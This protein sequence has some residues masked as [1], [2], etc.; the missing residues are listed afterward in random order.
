MPVETLGQERFDTISSA[1]RELVT[2]AAEVGIRKGTA[3]LAEIDLDGLEDE[4]SRFLDDNSGA[5]VGASYDYLESLVRKSMFRDLDDSSVAEVVA[6]SDGAELLTLARLAVHELEAVAQIG[7]TNPSVI[8]E[9]L[10]GDAI[11][12]MTDPAVTVSALIE[13]IL[14]V[15]GGPASGFKGE[16]TTVAV[17]AE[18]KI[19]YNTLSGNPYSQGS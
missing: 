18:F 13:H 16:D 12:I 17:F 15:S 1:T 10:L 7:T 9:Q 19:V 14:Y 8:Q 6:E 2:L 5:L 11:K 4:L 3:E